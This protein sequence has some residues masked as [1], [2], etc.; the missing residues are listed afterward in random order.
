MDTRIFQCIGYVHI[1]E[2][3]AVGYI[4]GDPGFL[5][6]T[7]IYIYIYIYIYIGYRYNKLVL[8]D[9][10]IYVHIGCIW[11]QEYIP[12]TKI[13]IKKTLNCVQ[14]YNL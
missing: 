7:R 1:K 2:I 6:D 11:I 13:C 4:D 14:K 5:L 8:F 3:R 10:R 12:H 9:I